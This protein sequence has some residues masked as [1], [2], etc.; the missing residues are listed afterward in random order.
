MPTRWQ[1]RGGPCAVAPRSE[2]QGDSAPAPPNAAGC[3]DCGVPSLS[4]AAARTRSMIIP[5]AMRSSAPFA[6]V[7]VLAIGPINKK[8]S[9]VNVGM[10]GDL[11]RLRALRR[12]ALSWVWVPEQ[13]P[14]PVY[15][16]GASATSCPDYANVRESFGAGGFGEGEICACV[17]ASA[18]VLVC[19]PSWVRGC[20][21]AWVRSWVHLFRAC[22]R[23]CVRSLTGVVHK[24][25]RSQYPSQTTSTRPT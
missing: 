16:S 6:P 24:R 7:T 10:F 20:V 2:A 22:L 17:R 5:A 1:A 9:G 21:G 14:A 8:N 15:C 4:I 11:Q 3:R 18:C 19:L 12:Q 23:A 25:G 13:A